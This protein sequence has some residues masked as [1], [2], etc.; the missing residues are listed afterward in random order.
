[1]T[2]RRVWAYTVEP[3]S[4]SSGDLTHLPA[5]FQWIWGCC[6]PLDVKDTSLCQK[7]TDMPSETSAV[8]ISL[9]SHPGRTGYGDHSEYTCS[10]FLKIH[11]SACQG[12][13][14]ET[15]AYD[16]QFSGRAQPGLRP[17]ASSGRLHEVRISW[18]T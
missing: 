8:F 16:V 9:T 5:S 18:L 11:L 14:C 10:S 17:P 13:S 4:L 15:R 7:V 3:V 6:L 2:R 12:G 1:M